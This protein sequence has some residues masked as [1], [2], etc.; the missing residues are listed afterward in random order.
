MK[1]NV[2]VLITCHNRLK[3]TKK[4]LE[5]IYLQKN[6]EK[7]NI[8]IFLVDDGSN[9]GT[10]EYVKENFPKIKLIQG[11]G[12]LYW[13]GGMYLAWEE[14][15]KYEQNFDYFLWVNDDVIFFE[16]GISTLLNTVINKDNIVVGSF[17]DPVSKK[18]TYG[19]V[20]SKKKFLNAFGLKLVEVN[21]FPQEVDGINGN[22]VLI[23]YL[24][25]NQ[26][27]KFD[28][29]FYHAGGDLDYALRARKKN[30]KIYLT[31]KHV[32]Y[33]ERSQSY[34]NVKSFKDIFE[35]KSLPPK[36]WFHF[37][38][39]HGGNLWILHF[40]FRFIKLCF[41]IIINIIIKK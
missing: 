39:K 31:H 25:F 22:G 4:C 5:S 21:G 29:Q 6:I 3:K 27:G 19:G 35:K 11:D 9:D 32:G 41:K 18:T 30:I 24:A 20:V 26:I 7:I 8:K 10:S 38:R 17:C 33:C 1:K 34:K 12:N 28:K 40:F 14:A 13:G 15:L 37:C 2:A 23:P 36:I 16:D